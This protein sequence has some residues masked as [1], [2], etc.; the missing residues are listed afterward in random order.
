MRSLRFITVG[1]ALFAVYGWS[2]AIQGQPTPATTAYTFAGNGLDFVTAL[3]VDAS[4][5]I[6]L[7][8]TTESTVM[9]GTSDAF[10]RVP[11]G[12][13][14]FVAK[15]SAAGQLVWATF[16]GGS[17]ALT[18][19]SSFVRDEVSALAVD[20]QGNV[21]VGGATTS[22]DFPIV[23]GYQRAKRSSAGTPEGFL[24]KLDSSGARLLYST[25]LG[26]SDGASS[27]R[28]IQVGPAGEVTVGV[29][30]AGRQ[31][32]VTRD[33]GAAGAAGAVVGRF[34]PSGSMVWLS[35]IGY[36]RDSLHGLTVDS[37]GRI[38]ALGWSS[39]MPCSVAGPSLTTCAGSYVQQ[40]D[41]SGSTAQLRWVMAGTPF[42]PLY[43]MLSASLDGRLLVTGS[44]V[45]SPVT[46][47]VNPWQWA[48][49]PDNSFAAVVGP[50]GATEVLTLVGGT[51]DTMRAATDP[52]GRLHFAYVSL[53]SSQGP[54]GAAPT[55]HPAGPMFR[56]SDRGDSWTTAGDG[57]I[58]SSGRLSFDVARGAIYLPTIYG[59]Y[60][61]TDRGDTWSLWRRTSSL[62]RE[63][64]VDPREPRAIYSREGGVVRRID[65]SG[66]LSTV[67]KG[68]QAIG[69]PGS[70]VH[71]M[72]V[73]PHDGSLWVLSDIGAE[74]SVDRGATWAV[75]NRGLPTGDPFSVPQELLI[76]QRRPGTMIV[77]T[78]SQLYRTVDNG[79]TWQPIAQASRTSSSRVIA[80]DASD[81]G[82]IYVED[83]ASDRL[84][85][86]RDAGRTWMSAIENIEVSSIAA[87]TVPPYQVTL[88]GTDTATGRS[89]VF[90]TTDA[91]RWSFRADIGPGTIS[92]D[93]ADPRQMWLIRDHQPLPYLLR[94]DRGRDASNYRWATGLFLNEFGYLGDIA[95]TRNGETLVAYSAFDEA[96]IGQLRYPDLNV[97]VV[98]VQR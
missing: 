77:A 94:M 62:V 69:S 24:S 1:I 87:S 40:L 90:V 34:Q 70:F 67:V 10:Q 84:I 98:R 12:N 39:A 23:N 65:E 93:P 19:P 28:A 72:S 27:V 85:V 14:F 89:G 11:R 61:S 53:G 16:L 76:D 43:G 29:Q 44:A 33:L 78:S 49:A 63:V 41:Q 8:G 83:E 60:R 64:I 57:V 7:A 9:P 97:R 56:S 73:S 32:E 96:R 95:A 15:L 20:S 71:A 22:P 52:S 42:P 88:S 91:V 37:V 68:S 25:Y 74:V 80:V 51:I 30:V 86:S 17:D 75:R 21:I 38:H 47:L 66:Q 58:G 13:D 81:A 82:R 46:Q 26:A 54:Y 92:L 18:N 36:G 31:F 45:Q 6:Y 3:A 55:P 59:I 5:N 4:E 79:A 48:A 50:T 35:R 2:P